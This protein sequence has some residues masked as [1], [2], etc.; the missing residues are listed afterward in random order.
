MSPAQHN[1][2]AHDDTAR[3]PER[4]RENGPGRGQDH[5]QGRGQGRDA[6][7]E[8]PRG[9]GPVMCTVHV[10][11]PAAA[12][13][14]VCRRPYGGRF[15]GV[16]PDGRAVC[17]RCAADEKLE[18]ASLDAPTSEVDAALAGGWA[19]AT[20]RIL[21]RPLVTIG[22]RYRG[23]VGPS[24]RYGFAAT[25]LGLVMWLGWS[26]I[27]QRDAIIEAV[28]ASSAERGLDASAGDVQLALWMMVPLLAALRLGLGVVAFHVGTRLAGADGTFRENA[29]VFALSSASMLFCVV[30]MQIGAL[31]SYLVWLMLTLSWVR[32]RYELNAWRSIV[33]LMPA[34]AVIWILPPY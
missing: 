11:T 26:L 14:T 1:D 15:L 28:L 18:L 10:E 20:A 4:D 3:D 5:D 21:L 17:Y 16:L 24:L 22:L 19:S 33:A 7:P 31:L 32:V 2:G 23:P 25:V 6:D 27:L 8:P 13:C 30:P 9:P 12:F 34:I 29:R